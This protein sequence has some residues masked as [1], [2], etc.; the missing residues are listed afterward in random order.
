MHVYVCVDEDTR[1]MIIILFTYLEIGR[2][3]LRNDQ[4]AL[5]SPL[6]VVL[7]HQV[8]G[9]P[10]TVG[11][12]GRRVGIHGRAAVPRQ[13]RHDD[14]VLELDLAIGNGQRLEQLGL[15]P[16]DLPG[17]A[18]DAAGWCCCLWVNV[19]TVVTDEEVSSHMKLF[20]F[21]FLLGKR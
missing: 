15:C 17:V 1:Y 2:D 14:A 18:H 21:S 6:R 5:G 7:G 19:L 11:I 4:T 13:R 8:I 20:C 10:G 12:L 3:G 16:V 9:V